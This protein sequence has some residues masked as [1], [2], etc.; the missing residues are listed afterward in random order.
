MEV[1]VQISI[2]LYVFLFLQKQFNLLPQFSTNV[3]CLHQSAMK[4]F[5]VQKYEQSIEF[6]Y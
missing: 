2:T 5:P 3:H 6:W 1:L 4:L